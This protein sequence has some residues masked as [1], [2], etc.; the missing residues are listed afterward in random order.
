MTTIAGNAGR[1]PHAGAKAELRRKFRRIRAAIPLDERKDAE[2]AA[3]EAL[4]A[5]IAAN[6]NLGA[7]AAYA[8]VGDEFPTAALIA[9]CRVAGLG[10]CLPRWDETAGRYRWAWFDEG[11]P[12]RKGPMSIPEPECADSPLAAEIGLYLVPGLAF[13]MA[14]TRLGYGGGWY[15]RLLRE[16]RPGAIFRG[17]CFPAQLS[18]V[19]LPREAHDIPVRPLCPGGVVAGADKGERGREG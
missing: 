16:A 19:P 9:V 18:A 5:L 4:K 6:G 14:G 13:D 11:A 1:P 8:S 2:K 17:L 15:D 3:A 7:V 12:L 10:V